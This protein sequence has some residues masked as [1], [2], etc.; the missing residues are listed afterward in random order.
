MSAEVLYSVPEV[1]KLWHCSRDHVYDQI[2]RGRLRTVRMGTGRRPKVRVPESSLNA[3]A[4]TEPP[5]PSTPP[6]PPGP[7]R[8]AA[9]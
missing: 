5:N 3:F 7:P 1:A 6:P 2:N 9:A 4:R 8:R